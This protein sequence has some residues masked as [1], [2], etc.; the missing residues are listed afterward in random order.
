MLFNNL[1]REN[2]KLQEEIK[3]MKK[4]R[5]YGHDQFSLWKIICIFVFL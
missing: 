1:I 2:M 5:Y 4:I 3:D